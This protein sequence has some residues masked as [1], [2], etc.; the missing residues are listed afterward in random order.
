MLDRKSPP[1]F[2]QDKTFH[3]LTPE[4]ERLTSG[5]Q[6]LFIHGGDQEVVKI[7]L[8]FR[9]GRW[10][11][12]KPGLSH[13][14]A[15]LLSKGTANLTSYQI[16]SIFDYSGVHLEIN[17]GLD[18]TSITLYGLTKKI[19]DV[20]DLLIDILAT[21]T[22]PE[23]EIQQAKDIY[24]QG[25]KINLEKTSYLAA[26]YFRKNLFGDNHPYGK[27]FE[28]EDVNNVNQTHLIDFR[29]KFYKSFVGFVSGKVSDKVKQDIAAKLNQL[30]PVN[31]PSKEYTKSP[32][33]LHTN[34]IDKQGSIQSSLRI[35][36]Q[37]VGRSHADYPGLLLLN[38]ILGGFFGSRLMKNIREEKGL[39]YGIHSSIHALK[40]ESYF[41]IGADV[42]KENRIISIE[43]IKKELERFRIEMIERDEL[44]VARNHFIGSLQSDMSTPFA[45]ADKIKTITL[46][47][48]KADYYQHL[49][50]A[51]MEISTENLQSLA[52]KY[53]TESELFTTSVG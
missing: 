53:L 13:F 5:N 9:A 46:F 35:G 22:F 34:H 28:P 37:I 31:I 4:N 38:H 15:I 39:T 41:V 1:A 7:E 51:M 11:E 52:Q 47:N 32:A 8:I 42:N 17:P 40:N 50:N 2:N 45:H 29:N 21:S 44:D 20:L 48:L 43:E 30:I 10:F 19:H 12:S 14:T 6:L 24:T 36:K 26:R 23:I 33:V 18:F 49:I 27:D 16:T 3:L 25:L